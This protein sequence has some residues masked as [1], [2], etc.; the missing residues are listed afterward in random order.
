[1][2][3]AS[4]P[5]A[6]PRLALI[7]PTWPY[8]G[9][10]AQYNTRLKQ[11]LEPLV[12]GLVTISFKRQYP[13]W[14]YPG[15][16]DIEHGAE[17]KREPG[18]QYVLDPFSP[19]SWAQAV[20]LVIQSGCTCAIFHWWT[21]FWAPAFALMA[22]RLRKRGVRVVFLCHNLADHD[23]NGL[24][25]QL[26]KRLLSSAQAY[27]VH[28]TD[29]AAALAN[30]RPEVPVLRRLHPVYDRF[31]APKRLLPKRG[32]LE[33]LFFGFIRPYKGLNVL[34]DAVESM[35]DN[36]L[37]L[38]VVGESWE[39]ADSAAIEASSERLGD[40]LEAHLKYVDDEDAAA[41]F[42]R[43]DIVALPYLSATGS[44]VVALAY[45]Y[46][47]PVVASRVGGLKDAV[48]EGT[49]GW[50]VLPG[51]STEL[52]SALRGISREAAAELARGIDELVAENTWDALAENICR[53]IV[54]DVGA[55]R[56]SCKGTR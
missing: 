47:K 50:L 4:G 27:I 32:R 30:L 11:A 52:A 54:Q 39:Q 15:Q 3:D 37:F 38:T 7:G 46:R 55:Q 40:N 18:V 43:A 35:A 44:G 49:T 20:E 14:L 33:I 21:L 41:Y 19:G 34:L 9:G 53:F 51:S 56:P 5:P 28:S 17:G 12:A 10:I 22:W 8:R 16:S 24:K 25:A 6:G 48:L 26:A 23:A 2:Y 45:H 36:E 31:P 29:Q 1:M 42:A 13:R